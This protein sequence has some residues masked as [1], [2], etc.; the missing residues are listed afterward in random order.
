MN[1]NDL[2]FNSTRRN[3]SSMLD[4]MYNVGSIISQCIKS[5]V[6]DRLC[7][8]VIRNTWPNVFLEWLLWT[9]K[10]V[11]NCAAIC[12]RF[13][14]W[15]IYCWI[16]SIYHTME[17]A[18]SFDIIQPLPTSQR[19]PKFLTCSYQSFIQWGYSQSSQRSNN[20]NNGICSNTYICRYCMPYLVT[21]SNVNEFTP[22]LFMKHLP[23]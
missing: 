16:D 21:H 10:N 1:T 9:E 5:Q 20:A 4:F 12:N 14:Q 11:V 7:V 17:K 3:T 23:L 2:K 13:K 6:N 22:L 15:L 8:C 19:G 18:A